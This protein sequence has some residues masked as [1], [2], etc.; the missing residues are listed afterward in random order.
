VRRFGPAHP[1]GAPA[2]S[3]GSRKIGRR[4]VTDEDN[5]IRFPEKVVGPG[6]REGIRLWM[7][8]SVDVPAKNHRVKE[9][10]E[11]KSGPLGSLD[12]GIT[13]GNKPKANAVI[14]K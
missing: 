14:S 1:Y 11:P 12:L 9:V 6:E 5:G 13:V 3:I 7:V 8:A 4:I 2:K 10:P